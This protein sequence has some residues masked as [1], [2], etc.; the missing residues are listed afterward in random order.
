MGNQRL[1]DLVIC[2]V[3]VYL[4]L[5][6]C[7]IGRPSLALSFLRWIGPAK[8]HHFSREVSM[9]MNTAGSREKMCDSN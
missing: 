2:V 5:S 8:P 6:L 7:V 4:A 1:Y 3:P 9:E